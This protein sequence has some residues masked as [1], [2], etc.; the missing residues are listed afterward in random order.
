MSLSEQFGQN[1]VLIYLTHLMHN[2]KSA[3]STYSYPS[4]KHTHFAKSLGYLLQ[5][6]SLYTA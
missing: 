1:C 4:I 2:F 6:V 3:F 5:Y